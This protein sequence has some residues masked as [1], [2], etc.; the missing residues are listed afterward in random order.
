[1]AKREGLQRISLDLPPE[2][3][4]RLAA[5]ARERVIGRSLLI[6]FLLTDGLDNLVPVDQFVRRR[7]DRLATIYGNDCPV[8]GQHEFDRVLLGGGV[9]CGF[10]DAVEPTTRDPNTPPPGEGQPTR[11]TP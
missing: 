8:G 1:M 6:E 7:S 2:L 11:R 9:A 5:A 10:C 4:E 3:I